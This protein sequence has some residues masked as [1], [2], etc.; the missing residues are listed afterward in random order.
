MK[1]EMGLYAGGM[2]EWC[3]DG[4]QDRE[5][6]KRRRAP[7]TEPPSILLPA[8]VSAAELVAGATT[9]GD[10]DL[11]LAKVGFWPDAR[12]RELL[13]LG[14]KRVILNCTRQWGKSTVTAAKAV[15]EGQRHPGSL[16]VVLSPSKRQSAEFL[17][18]AA[19]FVSRLGIRPKGDGDNEVSL[20]F[21]NQSRIVG[22][23]GKES[24]VRGFSAVRLMLVDEASRVREELYTAVRPMLAVG[25]GDL[26][27]MSTPNGKQGVFYETWTKGGEEWVR[28]AVPA[29]EC[30]RISAEFLE[31]ERRGMPDRTFRQEY[32]C[33]F[34]DCEEAVFREEDIAAAIDWGLEPVV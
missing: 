14:G 8:T 26:W 34:T 18:K 19:G 16:V 27:M 28:V 30:G 25:D 12:Q 5:G 9:T 20:A 10:L 11:F 17:R 29:T 32:M 31:R 33:E 7:G 13:E 21:P 23:P 3:G 4:D 6:R 22:L 1:F 15:W 2:D 24:T